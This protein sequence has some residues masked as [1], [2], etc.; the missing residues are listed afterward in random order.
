MN[1]YASSIFRLLTYPGKASTRGILFSSAFLVFLLNF[2][3]PS[4]T[5]LTPLS[6]LGSVAFVA[7]LYSIFAVVTDST[8]ESLISGA[9]VLVTYSANVPLLTSPGNATFGIVLADLVIVP[10]TVLLVYWDRS[11][12]DLEKS[13]K[14]V[15]ATLATFVLWSFLSAFVSNGPSSLA[16]FAFALSATRYLLYFFF[17]CLLIRHVS[18]FDVIY[19]LLIAV[20]GHVIVAISEAYLG[21]A[22]GFTQLGDAT[23]DHIGQFDFLFVEFTSGLFAGGFAGTSRVLVSILLLVAP[24]IVAVSAAQKGSRSS[25]LVPLALLPL[26]VFLVRISETDSGLGALVIALGLLAVFTAYELLVQKRSEFRCSFFTTIGSLTFTVAMF[27]MDS[28]TT[29]ESAS[30]AS[31]NG[32][33]VSPTGMLE[34]VLQLVQSISG[35]QLKNLSVRLNQ[36][37]AAIDLGLQFPLFG[38][39]GWNFEIISKSYGFEKSMVIHNTYLTHFA[40]LG[41]PGVLAFLVAILLPLVFAINLARTSEPVE[42]TTWWSLA[43]GLLAFHAYAFWTSIHASTVSYGVLWLLNGLIVGAWYRGSESE[44]EVAT[45]ASAE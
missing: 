8:F 29:A 31:Q 13:G 6:I 21:A 5:V 9:F 11:E 20:S 17:A 30:G 24:S 19:P 41:F 3:A 39:G 22:Y 43:F 34:S 23:G 14:Y 40:E 18:V 28:R 7:I 1:Q 27:G 10:F 25:K 26:T 45:Y 12:L 37:T 36:Y 44:R 35:I 38:I 32:T 15:L 2:F 4:L 33:D 16:S 42:A